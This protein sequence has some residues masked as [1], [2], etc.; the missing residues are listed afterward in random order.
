M[1]IPRGS[2]TACFSGYSG[3]SIRLFTA[4]WDLHTHTHKDRRVH[5]HAVRSDT[6]SPRRP[7][8]WIYQSRDCKLWS[9]INSDGVRQWGYREMVK[10]G[11]S[12]TSALYFNWQP[13]HCFPIHCGTTSIHHWSS[14][15]SIGIQAWSR[16][17]DVIMRK[18]GDV[19]A[20]ALRFNTSAVPQGPY[21]IL[22]THSFYIIQSGV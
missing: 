7:L 5:T 20:H 14:C 1:Q 2:R 13:W 8:P 10:Q 9:I 22:S 3:D 12:L 18:L 21:L 11:A 16:V 17:P 19:A 6:H 15:M 4:F